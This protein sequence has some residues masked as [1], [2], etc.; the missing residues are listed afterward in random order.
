MKVFSIMNQISLKSI[1]ISVFF[2]TCIYT[3]PSCSLKTV[4]SILDM[5]SGTKCK[6]LKRYYVNANDELEKL[7]LEYKESKR[8]GNLSEEE[9]VM[10]ED[11]IQDMKLHA[12]E[13]GY[14]WKDCMR[15]EK[16]N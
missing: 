5:F 11:S 9:I 16:D 6:D 4:G 13:L 10:Y 14:Q 1:V 2:I 8:E 12:D 15:Q 3:L 7:S